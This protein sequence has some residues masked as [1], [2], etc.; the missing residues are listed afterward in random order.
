[1]MQE[2]QKRKK[3]KDDIWDIS[4]YTDEEI[5]HNLLNMSNPT[6]RELEIKVWS[7]IQQYK[8][9]PPTPENMRWMNFYEQIYHRLFSFSD[10]EEESN[11]VIHKPIGL[12][13]TE[14]L[15]LIEGLETQ[16]TSKAPSTT[17]KNSNPK[18]EENTDDITKSTK[19]V[20]QLQYATGNINPLLKETIS[21]T[22]TIDS[23]YRDNKNESTTKFILN[24]TET[25]K[26]VVNISLYSIH[27]PFTWYTISKNYGSN[28][29]YLQGV[30]PGIENDNYKIVID[31]GNYTQV[32]LATVINNS[33]QTIKT[34]NTDISFGNT[35]I[36]YNPNN[37]L[38]T[39]F[40]DIQNVFTQHYYYLSFPNNPLQD[41]SGNT[42]LTDPSYILMRKSTIPSFL[43]IKDLS[44]NFD[45]IYS[46]IF[47]YTS[48][49]S[50]I[51]TISNT[52][53]ISNSIYPNNQIW[54]YQYQGTGLFDPSNSTILA[55]YSITIPTG[56]YSRISLTT[57]INNLIQTSTFIEPTVSFF[58]QIQLHDAN[59][60]AYFD[61]NIELNRNTTINQQYTKTAIFLPDD[62][63]N[64]NIWTG[65]CFQF[66]ARYPSYFINPN[67]STT[68]IG[69][70]FP[71]YQ[72]EIYSEYPT[73]NTNYII[74]ASVS[75]IFKTITP[76]YN[77]PENSFFLKIAPN[78]TG[79]ILPDYA[80]AINDAFN[81]IYDITSGL[82]IS[83][84]QIFNP[85]INTP[86]VIGPTDSIPY[87]D[88]DMNRTFNTNM[89]TIDISNSSL[90]K[91][92][93][94]GKYNGTR[95][96]IINLIDLS[97]SSYLIDFS[98]NYSAVINME[99]DTLLTI[100]PQ[101][102]TNYGNQ[103]APPFIV[104]PTYIN[105][106]NEKLYTNINTITADLQAAFTNFTSNILNENPIEKIKININP[107][108]QRLSTGE[109]YFNGNI[110]FSVNSTLTETNYSVSFYDPNPNS[111]YQ[112][113]SKYLHFKDNSGTYL[114]TDISYILSEYNVPGQSYSR[115]KGNNVILNERITIDNSNNT[116]SIIPLTSSKSLQSNQ[117]NYNYTIPA[118]VYTR[119]QLLNAINTAFQSYNDTYNSYIQLKTIN[120][121]QNS[122]FYIEINKVFTSSDYEFIFYDSSN[123]QQCSV[124]KTNTG[125]ASWDSTLGWILGFRE[126]TSYYFKNYISTPSIS[127]SDTNPTPPFNN[128][129]TLIA[130][131]TCSTTLFNY[132]ILTLDD[133]NQN[134]TNDGLVTITTIEKSIPLPSYANRS[135]FVCDPSSGL[136]L[137]TGITN[138]GSNNLTQNQIYS[139]TEIMNNNVNSDVSNGNVSIT[140][141]SYGPF[142]SDVLA[143]VPIKT[144]GVTNG[145]TIII[146]GGTLQTQNRKYFG[147]INLNRLLITL[148]DDRG[149]IVN[150]NNSNWSFT[151]LVDQIYK[152]S[153][154]ST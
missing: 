89:Y 8:T 17:P 138:S 83:A 10:D 64:N 31:S 127:P 148:Y 73:L 18:T 22:L 144:G 47:P 37:M 119:D 128:I 6:D 116:F 140:K 62:T 75:I 136:Y 67:N 32:T 114:N 139:I 57:V 121:K 135:N 126:N 130:D 143:I 44:Y 92:L 86:F 27:I 59:N 85:T 70:Y 30:S 118:D 79:Y 98:F 33:L 53:D 90:Y 72:N 141:F 84:N 61:F 60:N 50:S 69:R 9:S 56:N 91:I 101:P 109:E 41:Y 77:V 14:G 24:L 95:N 48:S 152:K 11:K 28:Y 5:I 16:T 40:V 145:Q 124:G 97:A 36:E 112:S 20:T 115:I 122:Y 134:H 25:I 13:L 35:R 42:S 110:T 149:H 151:L 29:F 63:S 137:Y 38:M 80:T 4:I 120:G 52:T 68:P 46:K 131:T 133:F 2:N 55:T 106:N 105:N 65:S 125:N 117:N 129:S 111:D 108:L 78:K 81:H 3:M 39:F 45:N 82:E 21:R 154:A 104:Y 15:E 94:I 58:E 150:L 43:G 51:Y 87:F 147:P 153:A 102:Y 103:N 146:D 19:L 142:I 26:N 7:S 71:F 1:M 99:C 23:Q 96:G 132:F 76:Y 34:T 100:Y 123:F 54:I 88:F 113:W 49:T 74:D 66:Q 12:E 107:T 93:N